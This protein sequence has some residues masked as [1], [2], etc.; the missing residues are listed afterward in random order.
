MTDPARTSLAPAR[1]LALLGIA[2]RALLSGGAE[3]PPP[4]RASRPAWLEKRRGVFVTLRMDGALRGCIGVVRPDAGLA[5][6]VA[7]CAAA[8]ACEDPRFPSLTPDE[9]GA[10]SIEISLLDPPFEVRDPAAI[11][12]GRHGLIVTRGTDRGLLLP[13]V[14]VEQGWD[15]ERFRRETCRKA[16]LEEDAWERGARLEAFCVE[17][18]SDEP[19]TAP[20]PSSPPPPRPATE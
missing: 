11:V 7:R 13:Q 16:G 5:E 19:A 2:R 3:G 18:V 20:R 8:A 15:V 1:R 10:C 6:T 9:A 12:L 17:V 4:E 14:A